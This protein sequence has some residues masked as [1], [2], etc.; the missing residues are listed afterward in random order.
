M[1]KKKTNKKLARRKGGKKKGFTLIELLIVIAIIG[2]L[3]SVVLVSLNSARGKARVASWKAS[4]AS[5]Q[6]GVGTCC[7]NG[8]S[9]S[10]TESTAIC[11]ETG[12]WPAIGTIAATTSTTDTVANCSISDPNFTFTVTGPSGVSACQY[13]YCNNAKCFFATTAAGAI[14]GTGGC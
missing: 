6:K 10:T 14:A 7:V 11:A 12:S 13:A 5:A 2:I 4:V 3:A 9:F 1:K 8:K